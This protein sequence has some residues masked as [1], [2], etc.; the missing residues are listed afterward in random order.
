MAEHVVSPPPLV[1]TIYCL[2]DPDTLEV[3]YVG[4]TRR[5]LK[6]RLSDHRCD[7]K[8]SHRTHW[9]RSVLRRGKDPLIEALELVVGEGWEERERYWIAE[10]RRRG[11]R[12]VNQTTG[13]E[14]GTRLDE[15]T[16][17]RISDAQKA[18]TGEP[19]SAAARKAY[20]G[21]F[22]RGEAIPTPVLPCSYC[23]QRA[24]VKRQRLNRSKSGRIFCSRECANR[25]RGEGARRKIRVICGYCGRFFETHPCR[26]K[27][28]GPLGL[29][30]SR[31]HASKSVYQ[32]FGDPRSHPKA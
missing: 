24:S 4:K 5:S 12:L 28:A 19:R 25:A 3:R 26:L 14:A 1:T 8:E 2:R 11:A 16:C 32:R 30:C 10:Y 7:K 13:G 17:K 27:H 22:E 20:A 6:R 31:S 15:A 29:F 21:R 23:H 9:F 18:I